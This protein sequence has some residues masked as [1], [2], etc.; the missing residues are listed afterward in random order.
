VRVLIAPDK[1]KGS[2]E[3]AEVASSLA[4]GIEG[5]L[6]GV[7]VDR[8]PVADGGEGTVAAALAAGYRA[9]TV[10]VTGPVGNPV[11]ATFAVHGEVAVVEMA[12]ASGL[13]VL[14]VRE[15]RQEFDAL[16]A[17]SRGTGELVS[18]ALDAGCHRVVLGIGGSANTDGGAGLLS[19]LGVRLLDRDGGP[20]PPGGGGL[21]RLETVDLTGLD[22]R[23]AGTEVVLAS[24]VE[25]PLLGPTGAA[26]VFAPQKGA[27]A[28]DV[29]LLD[30]ALAR[31]AAKLAEELG[32]DVHRWAGS[33]GAGAA[34]GVGF[35]ALAVLGAERRP[36]IDVVL[37]LV[38]LDARL[39]GVDA[40]VTG[41]GSLDSQSLGG[42]TPLGVARRAR[43]HHVPTVVAVCGRN[44][45]TVEQSRA[46]GFDRVFSLT[47]LEPDVER[48]MRDAAVLLERVGAEVGRELRATST[49]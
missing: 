15:G 31:F 14:P 25:N 49:R 34:G 19:A 2:L 7:E 11:Q 30:D 24:D 29:R 27:D 33:A 36:G 26:A 12:L 39:E 22:P 37:E 47:D 43:A 9:V 4:A 48:S 23:V 42:K 13:G 45:L 6:D 20:V 38:G 16:G 40:V 1:F 35:A 32:D 44:T 5:V 46:A 21:V 10:P 18:A 17:T 8:V 28:A 3:A 41:E